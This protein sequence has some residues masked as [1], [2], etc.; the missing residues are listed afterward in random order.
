MLDVNHQLYKLSEAIDWVSLEQEITHLIDQQYESLW[1][2]VSGS[3]YLKSFYDLSTEDL[4]DRWSECVYYRF[5]CT[6]QIDLEHPGDF[7]VPQEVLEQLS[8]DLAGEGY[9][10]MIKALQAT[11]FS[12]AEQNNIRATI[13]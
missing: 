13:H 3:I 5:F 9:D 1:R 6:G 2:L 8:L 7:P 10:A 11:D 4:I 12:V